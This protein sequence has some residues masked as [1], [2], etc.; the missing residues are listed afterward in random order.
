MKPGSVAGTRFSK[1]DRTFDSEAAKSK[2]S[3]HI[4]TPAIYDE[5]PERRFPVLY[6]LHGTSGGLAGIA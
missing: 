4:D 2:A 1:L 3:Y 5:E 6:W